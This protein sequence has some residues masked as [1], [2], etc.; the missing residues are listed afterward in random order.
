MGNVILEASDTEFRDITE[1]GKRDGKEKEIR[2]KRLGRE[3]PPGWTDAL[4]GF[5]VFEE[6]HETLMKIITWA[7][8]SKG[9]PGMELDKNSGSGI[10]NE[11]WKICWE[12]A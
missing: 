4:G 12:G 2:H 11:Q 9:K 6:D 3:Q 7:D 1:A 5:Q 10:P 8:W